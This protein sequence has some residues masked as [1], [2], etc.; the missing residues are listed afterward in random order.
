M[1][2]NF[3]PQPHWAR[4]CDSCGWERKEPPTLHGRSVRFNGQTAVIVGVGRG[5][6]PWPNEAQPNWKQTYH[7]MWRL[8]FPD[9]F[10]TAAEPFECALI[11]LR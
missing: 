4:R 5:K 11:P 2:K 3:C 6:D 8:R 10:L 7:V 9:G 1:A